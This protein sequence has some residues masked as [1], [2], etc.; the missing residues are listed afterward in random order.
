MDKL[1]ADYRVK[2]VYKDIQTDIPYNVFSAFIQEA[3]EA[4]M[5]AMI[6]EN[7]EIRIPSMGSIQ[8]KKSI[9]SVLDKNGNLKKKALRVDYQGTKMLWKEKY[10]G[11]SIEEIKQIPDRPIVYHKNKHSDGYIYKFIWD[12]LTCNMPMKSFYSFKAAR[13]FTRMLAKELKQDGTK[14]DFFE[15]RKLSRTYEN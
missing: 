6:F 8:I 11:M 13:G 4:V 9:P 15:S 2:D 5:T 12:K 3:N 10:P 7:L 1:V 14:I